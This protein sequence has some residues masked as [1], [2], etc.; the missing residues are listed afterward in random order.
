MPKT[1]IEA[2]EIIKP[3]LNFVSLVHR[4]ANQIPIRIMKK[5][6][7]PMI[8]VHARFRA[9][10][11]KAEK[12]PEVIGIVVKSDAPENQV[13]EALKAANIEPKTVTKSETEDGI[14][15]FT[16]G[17]LPADGLMIVQFPNDIGILVANVKKGFEYWL[18]E[19]AGFADK[20]RAEGFHPSLYT[21]VDVL[22]DYLCEKLHKSESPTQAAEFL[23]QAVDEFKQYIQ[24]AA[25]ALPEIAFYVDR[26]A[27]VAKTEII[28]T[29]SPQYDDAPPADDSIVKADT[30]EDEDKEDEKKKKKLVSRRFG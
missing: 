3:K 4:G 22:A 15:T 8:D 7:E 16:K 24:G 17:E 28:K 25:S 20:A 10:F 13:S 19:G 14:T 5:E 18:P 9:M 27:S 1:T 23:G 29:S 6:D 30:A 2:N 11:K 21:S 12:E 26:Y